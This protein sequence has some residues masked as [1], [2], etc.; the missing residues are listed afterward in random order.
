MSILILCDR[1]SSCNSDNSLCTR[2]SAIARESGKETDVVELNGDEIKPC[3]GCYRCWIKTPGLCAVTGDRA[4]AV[5]GQMARSDAVVFLSKITYGGY[6]YDIKS[7][8]DRSIPVI[9]PFFD[10]AGGEMHHKKRY[11]RL[12]YMISVGYGDFTPREKQTFISLAERNA[13]NMKTPKHFV[14]TFQ[15]A[16]ETDET[17]ETALALKTVLSQAIKRGL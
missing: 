14:F 6:S 5:L 4:A 1:E 2:I 16:D 17:G 7:F 13:L 15:D 12:P 8:L 9:S 10:F 11:D 3:R